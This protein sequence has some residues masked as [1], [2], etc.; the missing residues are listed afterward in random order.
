MP[1]IQ[2]SKLV[3]MS[4]YDSIPTR[5]SLLAKIRD[6]G[7]DA[8]WKEFCDSYGGL[9]RRLA[10]KAGLREDESDDVVEE[11]FVSVTRNI[12]GFEYDPAQCSFKH[13]LSQVVRWRIQDQFD[14]RLPIDCA[15]RPDPELGE[16]RSADQQESAVESE[17]EAVWEAEWR[18]H[19]I[20]AAAARVKKQISAKQFQIFFLHVLKEMPVA[21]VIQRLKVT[22]TQV[23]LAK[24]RV[25]RLFRKELEAVQE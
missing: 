3:V 10:L 12:G 15:A 9:V 19:L 7:N 23:Y 25:G 24:L 21:E 6:L 20:E 17:L 2:E 16:S 11:V 5:G 13:W 4:K 1:L 18:Q 14:K 8:A 22:R